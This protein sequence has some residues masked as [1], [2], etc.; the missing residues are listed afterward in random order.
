MGQ[1]G[2]V[3]VRKRITDSTIENMA[4]AERS[5]NGTIDDVIPST[6]PYA[7]GTWMFDGKIEMTA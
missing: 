1:R 5:A 2:A 4:M 6:Q 3:E 7:P